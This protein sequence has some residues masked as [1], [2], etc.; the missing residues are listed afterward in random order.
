[1]SQSKI[2][3]PIASK[4]ITIPAEL[5][6]A[7]K[8]A[9]LPFLTQEPPKIKSS[10]SK[11]LSRFFK[12]LATKSPK[13]CTKSTEA[14]TQYK[15]TFVPV[16]KK[17]KT[18]LESKTEVTEIVWYNNSEITSNAIELAQRIWEEDNT[19]YKSLDS[20][21]EWIGNGKEESNSILQS[22]MSHFDFKGL[23]LEQAFR[24]LCSK[25]YLKGETQQ[26]D[27]VL[28]QFSARYYE[29]NP[30]SIFGSIDVV[31]AI[32]YSLLLLNTDLH[33][34]Q[35][36]YKKMSQSAFIK[37]TMSAIT[38]QDNMLSSEARIPLQRTNSNTSTSTQSS[39]ASKSWE[40]EVKNM[41]KQMYS[42][43]RCSQITN[44]SSPVTTVCHNSVGA[45]FRRSVGSIIKK[46][47]VRDDE[48]IKSVKSAV[49]SI[50]HYQAV[51]SHLQ[52]TD[53]PVSYTSNA[54]YYKE[55]MV[56]RKHLLESKTQKAKHRDWKECFMVIERSQLRMYKLD[57]TATSE[58]VSLGGG[59]WMAHAQLM[60]AI[61]LKHALASALPSGYSRQ[62]QHAF[63]L[64]ESNGAVHVFQV[65]SD[66]QVEEWI[67]T[68]N[69]WAARE[70]KE[71]LIGGVG[72]MEYGWVNCLETNV[73]CAMV[74]EWQSPAAP[75]SSSMLEESAQVQ[76]L[77]KH[78]QDLTNQLDQHHDI[79]S[80]M[81]SHF[82]GSRFN[83]I[84]MNNWESKSLYLLSEI[85]KYQNY[86]NSIE[87]SLALQASIMA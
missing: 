62:R 46:K 52:S 16:V 48:S 29:C 71:P 70:S 43:I 65:G 26:I 83:V 84:A 30:Q 5:T 6:P 85:I 66:E 23:K 82:I 80:K 9:A 7:Q 47:V 64:Q 18:V 79:K 10:K 57:T 69:Y 60:G 49:S 17:S 35:G 44:P 15:L 2:V 31:H 24:T 27:R 3:T 42:S 1:M 81:E 19:V 41:L 76:A 45:T 13:T 37:N 28:L 39:S 75:I 55:G 33:V 11:S 32:V 72:S 38:I 36:D 68:C 22:Y 56:A 78:V 87:K 34:A 21:V 25:L 73:S 14:Q 63:T 4:P 40:I 8:E 58:S 50:M 54:P 20:I 12:K 77:Y 61:D 51:A 53:L 86:C 67:S 59:N 74:Y